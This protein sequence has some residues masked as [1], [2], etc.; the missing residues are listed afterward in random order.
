MPWLRTRLLTAVALLAVVLVAPA[1]ARPQPPH[2]LAE[3]V[4]EALRKERGLR[5]LEVAV[6]GGEITLA[7]EV[8]TF[9]L[10]HDAVQRA[11]GVPGVGS[12]VSEIAVPAGESD[13]GLAEEVGSVLRR[14]PDMTVWDFVGASVDQGVVMLAGWVTP[15]LD[16]AGEIF[17]RIAKLRGVQDIRGGIERLPASIQ[18][19]RLRQAIGRRVFGSISFMRF[20]RVQPPP[21]R[22]LVSNSSVTLAGYVQ[23]DLERRELELLV[24][25]IQGVSR[26]SNQLQTFR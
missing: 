19:E 4:E 16:K 26:I 25:E 7:G 23:S 5:G 20:A 18:D 21:F 12:V 13:E 2:A 15:E 10:K 8:A 17:E 1:P 6:T 3:A 11:L 22:I 24:G 9:W 14:Y